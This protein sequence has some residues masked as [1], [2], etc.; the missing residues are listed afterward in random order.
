MDSQSKGTPGWH[1]QERKKVDV[2]ESHT[3]EPPCDE[4]FL[5]DV[6]APH[7]NEAYTT[8]HLPASASKKGMASLQIKVDNG[9][10][11]NVLPLHQTP[12]SQLH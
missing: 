2:I 6:H 1:G 11:G 5:D 3:E 10:S 9:A 12:L 4:I 8:V 7:T